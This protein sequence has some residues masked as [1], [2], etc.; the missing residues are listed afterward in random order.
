LLA[1]LNALLAT[2]VNVLGAKYSS[3]E[4]AFNFTIGLQDHDLLVWTLTC[5][6]ALALTSKTF[7]ITIPRDRGFG[8]TLRNMAGGRGLGLGFG[9]L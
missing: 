7:N 6:V 8:F 5:Y 4:T 3:S 9:G 1:K 2:N